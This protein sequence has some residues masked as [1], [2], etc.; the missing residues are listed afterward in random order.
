MRL[1]RTLHPPGGA[2]ALLAVIRTNE[3]HNLGFFYVVA[4]VGI[5]ATV[6]LSLGLVIN[7]IRGSRRYPK[8]WFS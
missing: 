8:S 4:P 6:L 2:T 5:G 1:T 7:N 3:I